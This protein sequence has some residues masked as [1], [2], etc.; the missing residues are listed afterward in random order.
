MKIGVIG[1][2]YMGSGLGKLW[3]GKGH[4][5][6]FGSRDPDRGKTL[7]A[8]VG[9]GAR[10]GPV[11]A[12]AEFGDAVLFAVPWRAVEETLDAAGSLANKVLMDC[13]NPLTPDYMTLLVGHSDSGAEQIARRATGARVVK[14]F[15]HIYAQIIHTSPRLG[16][17]DA[18]VFF[19]GDDAGAK[20]TVSELA[21]EIGFDPV[22]AGPLRNARYLE[23]VAELMVQLAY[24]LGYG[25]DRGLKLIC[26]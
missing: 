12:A 17:L 6:M 9:H 11:R 2:G 26:R 22:D 19:C 25:T 18:T 20:K 23:P 3:A 13:S 1:T 8:S 14:A 7:A 16:T 4:D 24:G 15:N 5:V 10:G 21:R